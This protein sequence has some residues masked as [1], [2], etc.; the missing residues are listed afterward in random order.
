MQDPDGRWRTS[1]M[2][3]LDLFRTDWFYL[4]GTTPNGVQL[5]RVQALDFQTVFG[6]DLSV[7]NTV[8]LPC[9]EPKVLAQIRVGINN[10]APRIASHTQDERYRFKISLCQLYVIHHIEIGSNGFYD[11]KHC[12]LLFQAL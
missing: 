12:V 3:K 5:L 11:P 9:T 4:D 8:T 10:C 1:F 2:A 7:L 6:G